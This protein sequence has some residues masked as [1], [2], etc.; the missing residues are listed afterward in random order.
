MAIFVSGEESS[1]GLWFMILSLCYVFFFEIS[2]GSLIWLVFVELL[3][4]KHFGFAVLFNWL[5]NAVV[6]AVFSFTTDLKYYE[7][8]IYAMFGLTVSLFLWLIF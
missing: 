1:D 7:L 5:S 2:F 4:L 8:L 3:P 6:L